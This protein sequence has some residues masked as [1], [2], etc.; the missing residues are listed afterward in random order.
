MSIRKLASIAI[1][2]I[3]AASSANAAEVFVTTNISTSTTWTA[4]NVYRLQ[5]QIY[6]LPGATLTIE[7]GTLVASIPTPNGSGSLAVC[8]GARIYV[9]G[10]AQNPVIMTSSLDTFTS[11]REAANEWG[12]LTIM[13]QA[14]IGKYGPS[15][16]NNTPT[17][18]PNN[19]AP[20]EG[21]I[22][23]FP[24]DPNVLYGGGNDDDNSGCIS[25]LSI[26]YG[27]RVVGLG[28]ELNGLSLGGIGRETGLNFIEIMN[29]V[30]DGIEIWGGTVNLK[31]FS[32]WNIGDDSLDID[33]GYRGKV[34]FGLIVQGYSVDAAQGSGVGD[35]CVEI[36]GAE[37]SDAQPVTTSVAYN[38][39][40]IGQPVP[41]A[42]DHGF[43]YRDGARMQFKNAIVMDL[44]E[45]LV[46]NDNVDGDGGSGYGFN[47][48]LTWAQVWSTPYTSFSTVNAPPNPA[49]FYTAQTTGNL[50][51]ITDSVF[52]R[53]LD[54]SAY[55]TA[56]SVGVFDASNRNTLIPGNAVASTPIAQI[57]RG[58]PVTR[59]G[60]T[61]L[62]VV[63][64]DP[65]PVGPAATAQ[66]GAPNDGFYTSPALY[67]GAF[68]PGNT[69]WL[70]GWS[71][72]S[73]FGFIVPPPGGCTL[74]TFPGCVDVPSIPGDLNGDGVV[75]G[76]DLSIM[77]G[78]WGKCPG[79]NGDLNGDG[80]VNGADLSIL[81]SN[82]T[83]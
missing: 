54:P 39:T 32:I 16:P 40:L 67:A 48:T 17:P 42:G 43:A 71:A 64:L 83:S 29:N 4:N 77:L 18:N 79:C 26:R 20:M 3:V 10:T 21:L 47:G 44:G 34:Q 25:Y 75:N 27:G 35:N 45:R 55:N 70:C 62:P 78:E 65:R 28:N 73:R 9:R 63:S 53:N 56:T 76:A 61:M 57:T 60:K 1:G 68:P 38:M 33:Q 2:G 69:N 66:Q 6:V 82:W 36:D 30:D 23:Q 41:G 52:F 50:C 46:Q 81:L 51:Q 8:R 15:T 80:V 59:G 22:A 12:N 14:Y 11:W 49:A 58:A 13:G 72:A 37:N 24:G 7:P 74:P 5:N 31:N 19:L